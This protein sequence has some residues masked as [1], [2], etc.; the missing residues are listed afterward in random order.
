[1][2]RDDDAEHGISEELQTL[3][4]LDRT[5]LGAPR[6]VPEREIQQLRAREAVREQGAELVAGVEAL[7]VRAGR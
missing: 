1:M 5:V 4:R 7:V 3:V 6:P 2:V